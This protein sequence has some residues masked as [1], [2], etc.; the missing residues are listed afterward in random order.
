MSLLHDM[1]TGRKLMIAFL[2]MTS[3]VVG[4][5]VLGITRLAGA[6]ARIDDLDVNSLVAIDQL[7]NV[8]LNLSEAKNHVLEIGYATDQAEREATLSELADHDAAL[9]AAWAAYIQHNMAG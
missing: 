1:P 3:L 7:G 5:G 4:A 9:D 6:Q 2:V 8:R